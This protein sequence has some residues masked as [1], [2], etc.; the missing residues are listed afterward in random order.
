MYHV[1]DYTIEPF[2]ELFLTK[3]LRIPFQVSPWCLLF[4]YLART[5]EGVHVYET[6]HF[7]IISSFFIPR[8]K[9]DH[10]AIVL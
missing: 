8:A 6:R 2:Y 7:N 10:S 9:P 1:S 4:Q 3:L 5:V